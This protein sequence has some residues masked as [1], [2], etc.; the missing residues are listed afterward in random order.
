MRGQ[1][2][3]KLRRETDKPIRARNV[4]SM[5]NT[6]NQQNLKLNNANSKGQSMLESTWKKKQ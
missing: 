6:V 4:A 5:I 3:I 2:R 1:E